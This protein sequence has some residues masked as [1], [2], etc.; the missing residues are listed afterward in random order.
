MAVAAGEAEAAR[1]SRPAASVSAPVSSR[2]L[3]PRRARRRSRGRAGRTSASARSSAGAVVC[4]VPPRPPAARWSTTRCLADPRAPGRAR[5]ARGRDARVAGASYQGVFRNPLCDPY[6]LGV[7][8]GA[9]LGAT[10]AIVYTSTARG[11][12]VDG[13][14]RLFVGAI[15]AVVVT[16]RSAARPAPP[17]TGALVLAGV[18]VRLHR[19]GSDLHPATAPNSSRT[20]TRGSWRLRDRDVARRRDLRAVHCGELARPSPSS[21]RAR[22]AERRRRRSGEPRR[23]TSRARGS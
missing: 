7:A 17:V 15:P 12:G 10:L 11:G 9:G 20:S 4:P 23:S 13:A 2:R 6:L 22:R 21:P 8:G 14:A 1:G 16:S 18:T 3:P 19:G 5:R